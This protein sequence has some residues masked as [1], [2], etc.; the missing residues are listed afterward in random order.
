MRIRPWCDF[1]RRRLTLCGYGDVSLRIKH[2]P[3]I[4]RNSFKRPNPPPLR[5]GRGRK[6]KLLAKEDPSPGQTP[7][8]DLETDEYT[9]GPRWVYLLLERWNSRTPLDKVLYGSFGCLLFASL[10]VYDIRYRLS[11]YDR[12]DVDRE[13]IT[14]AEIG[15]AP[16]GVVAKSLLM[17]QRPLRRS[18]IE[19]DRDVTG[20]DERPS[21]KIPR[22]RRELLKMM[23]EKRRSS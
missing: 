6:Q 14:T 22:G 20:S 10:I 5:V 4:E 16:E 18:E 17:A 15:K 13:D 12:F 8:T 19:R 2:I 3:R 7:D 11:K 21:V 23:E 1:A 9:P